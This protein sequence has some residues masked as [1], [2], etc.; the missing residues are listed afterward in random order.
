MGVTISRP[1]EFR[2]MRERS[3][4]YDYEVHGPGAFKRT[5]EEREQEEREERCRRRK[6][7]QLRE[8]EEELRRIKE[9][10]LLVAENTKIRGGVLDHDNMRRT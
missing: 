10:I 9:K 6:A 2:G 7:Q 8:V 4:S 3:P 5:R 1:E